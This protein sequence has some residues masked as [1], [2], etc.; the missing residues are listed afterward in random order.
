MYGLDIK[1]KNRYE[2]YIYKLLKNTNVQAYIW[3]INVDDVII[4]TEHG[5]RQGLFNERITEGNNFWNVIQKDSY[6]LIF[7]DCKA[8]KN[9][10]NVKEISNGMDMLHSGCD[11]VFMCTDC[12][13]I[14][15]YCKDENL[16]NTIKLNCND[17]D[18]I[19][20]CDIDKK[21]ILNRQMIAF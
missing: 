10:E 14:E 12:T 4:K 6:Y 13:N 19:S 9:L 3:Q 18:I 5:S 11:L 21:E 20:F 17:P 2:K 1:I 7:S 8:F 15:I 16:Y